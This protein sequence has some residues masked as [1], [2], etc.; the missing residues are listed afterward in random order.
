MLLY[1]EITT[2]ITKVKKKDKIRITT[3]KKYV[4]NKQKKSCVIGWFA[5][6]KMNFPWKIS[7]YY[8]DDNYSIPLL[9]NE[10]KASVNIIVETTYKNH[11]K[12]S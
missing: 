2:T 4:M 1:D 9:Q 5:G 12:K 3:Y 11:K 10:Y 6:K 8:F 7:Y